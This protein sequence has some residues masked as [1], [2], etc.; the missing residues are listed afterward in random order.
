MNVH[1]DT[2]ARLPYPD[3]NIADEARKNIVNKPMLV[4]SPWI[5]G[6]CSR[7]LPEDYHEA[8]L[9]VKCASLQLPRERSLKTPGAL[10]ERPME[11]SQSCSR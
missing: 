9:A 10:Q 3:R 5:N 11:Q 8:E 4:P 6:L 2:Y 1:A 7:K